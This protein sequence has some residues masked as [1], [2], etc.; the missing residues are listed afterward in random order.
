M[1]TIQEAIIALAI[2]REVLERLYGVDY[3]EIDGIEDELLEQREADIQGVGFNK[4]TLT[5]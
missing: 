5:P 4:C 2:G 3:D 1:T